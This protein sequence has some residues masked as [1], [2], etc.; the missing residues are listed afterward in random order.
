MNA[1]YCM[2]LSLVDASL[3]PGTKLKCLLF[4]RN[5]SQLPAVG[6]IGDIVRLHRLKASARCTRAHTHACIHLNTHTYYTYYTY[7]VLSHV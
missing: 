5:V 4:A 1:D 2:V 3:D 7:C 6:N